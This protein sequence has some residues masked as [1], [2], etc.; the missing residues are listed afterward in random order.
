MSTLV[1]YH[2]FSQTT[3]ISNISDVEPAGSCLQLLDKKNGSRWRRPIDAV[4]LKAHLAAAHNREMASWAVDTVFPPGVFITRIP[5]LVASLTSMLSMPTP[6]RPITFM[7][8]A[9]DS[10]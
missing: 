4:L 6:A 8:V 9:L 2:A 3:T 1:Y 7:F 5:R 10:S